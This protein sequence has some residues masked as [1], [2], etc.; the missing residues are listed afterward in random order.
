[1]TQSAPDFGRDL[2]CTFDLDLAMAEVTGLPVLAQALVRRL[3]T[4]AGSLVGDPN[5]GYDLLGEIDDDLDPQDVAAIAQNVDAEFLKD[6]RVSGS[7]TTAT[8][9]NGAIVTSSMVTAAGGTYKL[10]LGIGQIVT[11]LSLNQTA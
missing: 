6:E 3:Q 8:Y 1:M 10:V 5:Y 2:A 7:T 4:P 11:I 9:A